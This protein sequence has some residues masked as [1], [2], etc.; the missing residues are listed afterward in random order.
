MTEL[1]VVVPVYNEEGAIETLVDDLG[2]VLTPLFDELQVIVV[3]DAS[4]DETPAILARLAHDRPWL[5][6]ERVAVNAGHGPAVVR[7]LES[8]R[9]DWVFQIDSDGQFVVAELPLLWARRDDSDL[10]LGIRQNRRDPTHRLLLTRA[11]RAAASLLVGARMR[12]VN[13]PFRLL[14]RS[15][16]EDLQPLIGPST[17]APNIF[18]AVGARVRGWRV[19]ELPATH[20]PRVTGTGSLRALRLVR[21]SLRALGQLLAYRVRLRRLPARGTL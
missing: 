4:T 5:H 7:G 10:V 8:A 17:L 15:V 1:S 19:V 21:F 9:A 11:V 2:S 20:R 14:R 13:T 3:D 18:V 12:D 6:V 16:W